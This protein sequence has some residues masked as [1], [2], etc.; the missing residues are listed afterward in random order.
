MKIAVVHPYPWPEV[1]RGAERYLDDL[2]RYL[3]GQG[4]EVTI[5]TGAP[6][7]TIG[8]A[9][10]AR[11]TELR[12]D[13]VTL[14]RRPRFGGGP[15]GRFGVT[16]M[17]TFGAMALGPLARLR[18]DV[19]HALTPTA[20]LA[21]VLLRRPTLYTVL[22][23]PDTEQLPTQALPRR[24]FRLAVRHATAAATL[25]RASAAALAASVGRTARRPA[26]WSPPRPVPCGS[27]APKRPTEDPLLRHPDRPPQ[28]G[29]ARS[30]R[31]RRTAR[32]PP[33]RPPGVV[34]ARATPVGRWPRLPLSAIMS[35]RPS[36]YWGR[37]APS[38]SR[39]ATGRPR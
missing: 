36:T 34:R 6:R 37:D 19:V 17:E 38:R 30:R 9:E 31:L 14:E 15:T 22:G 28:A 4:H 26:P 32:R 13:G 35:Q 24:A 11:R 8:G 10:P 18:P 5:V 23:H 20:A 1:R 25:S 16:Q 27:R 2:S 12:G 29:R 39:A 3:T 33:R 7:R 21:G